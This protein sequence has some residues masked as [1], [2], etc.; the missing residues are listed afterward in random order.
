MKSPEQCESLE[1]VRAGI[2]AID[3]QIIAA[4]GRRAGFVKAAARFKSS[5]ADV[6]APER[7][8]AMLQARREWAEY[9]GLSPDVIEKM[10]RDLVSYFIACEKAHWQ[11]QSPP[12]PLP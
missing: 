7:F 6:H 2:D 10:Y 9:E 8:A 1:E 12:V 4:L 5:E 3:R 11:A